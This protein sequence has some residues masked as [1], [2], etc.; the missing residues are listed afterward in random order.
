[1]GTSFV[2]GRR[3]V[4]A[5]SFRWRESRGPFVQTE[6]VGGEAG[7]IVPGC[8]NGAKDQYYELREDFRPIAFVSSAQD[9]E[10]SPGG[11]FVLR[12]N[13]PLGEFYHA[14]EG[15]VAE[16]HPGLGVDFAVLTT[17]IKES[18]MR[19]RLMAALGLCA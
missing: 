3:G 11:T 16:I 9:E 8:G 1:M 17:Q 12:T 19:E 10:P 18:L 7:H 14:A 5:K 2:A 4:C 15:A 6:R 13:A